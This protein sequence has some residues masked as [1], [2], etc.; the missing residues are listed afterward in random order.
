MWSMSKLFFNAIKKT[1]LFF[2]SV[3]MWARLL[4]YSVYMI[5]I[6]KKNSTDLKLNPPHLHILIETL[7]SNKQW[8]NQIRV[9]SVST[10]QATTDRTWRRATDAQ[11]LHMT[12][13]TA[14]C[15]RVQLCHSESVTFVNMKLPRLSQVTGLPSII[16]PRPPV[17]LSDN[18]SPCPSTQTG[19]LWESRLQSNTVVNKAVKVT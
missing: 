8:L 12:R 6:L 15:G 18:T 9:S 1:G 19:A 13:Q 14:E 3:S 17:S 5:I 4:F 10:H 2:P 11:T 7:R 16:H